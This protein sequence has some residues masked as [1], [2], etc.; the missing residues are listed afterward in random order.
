MPF[1]SM[2]TTGAK[3]G[4]PRTAA[5]LYFN[6][7]DDVILIASNYGGTRHPAWYHNL[8][9]NPTAELRRGD[10]SGTYVGR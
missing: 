8:K 3:S 9:A 6:D 1:V 10:R 4:E 7:G 5:V 2:T